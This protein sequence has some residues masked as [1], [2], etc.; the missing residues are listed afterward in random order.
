MVIVLRTVIYNFMLSTFA[1]ALIK[2]TIGPNMLNI[3]G[4]KE[5]EAATI[6]ITVNNSHV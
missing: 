5:P 6:F 3:Q 1:G 4:G 2:A